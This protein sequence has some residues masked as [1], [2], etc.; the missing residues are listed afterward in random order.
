M[1]KERDNGAMQAKLHFIMLLGL[2]H[3]IS[4]VTP[5]RADIKFSEHPT[6]PSFI[7]ILTD[8]QSWVGSSLRMDPNDARSQ[9]DFFHTPQMERMAALGMCFKYGYA[10]APFCCPSRRSLLTGQSPARH[11][12]QKRQPGWC[13]EFNTQLTIPRILKDADHAYETAHFGKWDFRFDAPSPEDMGYDQSDGITGNGTGGAKGTGGPS[14]RNDPKRMFEITD[15]AINFMKTSVSAKRP[16]YLQVSH[17]AVH[18]DIFYRETTLAHT[19]S[20]ILGSKHTSPPFAA[21]TEDLDH[22]VGKLLDAVEKLRP[23]AGPIYLFF[24]SDNG[25][26]EAI[27]TEANPRQKPRNHPL[28][29]GKGSMYEGGIRVPFIVIGPG[30]APGSHCNIPVTGLDI[31]PTLAALSGYRKPLP[32]SID[33]GSLTGVFKH[34]NRGRVDRYEPFLFFHQAVTRKPQTALIEYPYKLVKTWDK[35]LVELF[36]LHSDPGETFNLAFEASKQA[37]EMQARMIAFL[38]KTDAETLKTM[39]KVSLKKMFQ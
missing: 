29:D 39:D 30:I 6:P 22:A 24:M 21:M 33:G 15:K 7:V 25:G 35:N 1:D 2:V 32:K 38:E 34:G 37:Q 31:L 12:Y 17:Y 5:T 16:F 20:R 14:A 8:D 3:L 28:R 4:S 19:R 23:T 26:R 11:V 13:R 10:P 27:P 18:L 36:N 9:S